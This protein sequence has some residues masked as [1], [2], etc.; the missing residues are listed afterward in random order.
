MSGEKGEGEGEC[1]RGGLSRMKS[2]RR[3]KHF[4]NLS[5]NRQTSLTKAEDFP[6]QQCLDVRLNPSTMLALTIAITFQQI[7]ENF[8]VV[9]ERNQERNVV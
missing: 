3:I 9:L 8:V 4:I 2:F 6:F 1:A 7:F 5:I